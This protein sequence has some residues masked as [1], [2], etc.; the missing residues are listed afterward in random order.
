MIAASVSVDSSTAQSALTDLVARQLP[1]ALSRA[2]NQAVFDVRAREQASHRES[3]T[4][5]RPWVLRGYKVKLARKNDRPIAAR[6][7][8][9]PSRD[10][11]AK[12]EEG[13]TKT[14]QRSLAVPVTGGPARSSIRMVTPDRWRV[15]NLLLRKHV[16]KT[17][18]IQLKGQYNTFVVRTGSS[19][20]ILQRTRRAVKVVYAFKR[21]VPI[22][23]SL[24]FYFTA[25]QY[26]DAEWPR[27]VGQALAD[28]V[29]T[30][31]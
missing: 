30:A 6:L 11:L 5:R 24:K 2:V 7:W 25:Q 18:K 21:S 23:A 9:D 3:F 10:F 16:T 22:P 28:A 13:G 27:I 20:L 12:F 17:G 29:R 8:L 4:I 26:V 15:R 19:T 14:G 31:R 1:F